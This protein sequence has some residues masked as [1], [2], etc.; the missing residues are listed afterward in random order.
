MV[1]N[2]K[3]VED[4]IVYGK[5][6]VSSTHAK[7]LLANLLERNPLELLNILDMEVSSDI[8]EK[9][10]LQISNLQN[11]NPIQYVMGKSCFYG[12]DYFVNE[13]TL[14][15]R[16]ETEELV[17][18]TLNYIKEN[19]SDIPLDI[20]DLGTGTGCIGITLKK[21]IPNSNVTLVDIDPNTLK[22]AETN[23]KNLEADVELIESDFFEKING[24]FDIV[25]S[26]PPY[27]KDNESIEDV[28]KDN[29][30]HLA[31]YAGAD[32]LDCYKKILSTIKP[33]L[34]DNYLIAFEIGY[35]QK[36]DIINLVHKYL[37]DSIIECYKD[38]QE[39]DRMIFIQNKK[40]LN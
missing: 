1:N 38:L 2:P 29:E 40:T 33:Y 37:P 19:F 36:E 35:S 39:R 10:M 3:T 26:N 7:M 13:N 5:S 28:V 8:I 23:A 12:N 27:I 9:Y 6:K 15:P 21:Y 4:L 18:K 34:K 22:V 14:I 16:F 20:I 25:I 31:L 32:G 17:E 11:N 24:K 30:P